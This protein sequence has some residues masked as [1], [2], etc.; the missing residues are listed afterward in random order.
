MFSTKAIVHVLISILMLASLSPGSLPVASAGPAPATAAPQQSAAP[1][2]DALNLALVDHLGGNVNAVF[3]AGSYAYAGFGAELAVLDVSDPAH[4][5]RLG[6][7]ILACGY[8][9]SANPPPRSRRVS[10]IQTP[11]SPA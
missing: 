11:S 5:V 9:T 3:V 10:S 2:V 1:S 7:L 8:L 4:M 6:Y